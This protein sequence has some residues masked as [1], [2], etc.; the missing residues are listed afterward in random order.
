VSG[1]KTWIRASET[2]SSSMS[3]GRT[4]YDE[5]MTGHD[6]AACAGRVDELLVAEVFDDLGLASRWP[7]RR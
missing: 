6:V 4:L 1:S 7:W 5:S 2:F 3:P